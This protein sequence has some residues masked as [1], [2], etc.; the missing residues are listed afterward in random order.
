MGR[1]WQSHE[2]ERTVSQAVGSLAAKL[3]LMPGK[4]PADV[5]EDKVE[6]DF[7]SVVPPVA[8][9]MLANVRAYVICQLLEED[10]LRHPLWPGTA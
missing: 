4:T 1:N 6:T 7:D 8:T 10:A 9:E 2:T 3:G 5:A